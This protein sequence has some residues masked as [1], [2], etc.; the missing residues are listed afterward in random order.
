MTTPSRPMT[1]RVPG[2]GSVFAKGH[3][4]VGGRQ[5][6]TRNK[7]TVLIEALRNALN[8]SGGEAWL[9]KL[10]KVDRRTFAMLLARTIPQETTLKGSAK[11][12][13]VIQVLPEDK[14]L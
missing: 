12:P 5:K 10:A 1:R 3:R 11:Q 7:V 13:L 6:G 4:K 14:D 2:H 8:D 9:R